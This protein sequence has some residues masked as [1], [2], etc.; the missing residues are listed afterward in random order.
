MTPED[1][2]KLETTAHSHGMTAAYFIRSIVFAA[3]EL[4][5]A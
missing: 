2:L 1:R 3:K 4:Q 5:A